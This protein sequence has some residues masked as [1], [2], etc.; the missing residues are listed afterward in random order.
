MRKW[1]KSEAKILY[2][3]SLDIFIGNVLLSWD[4]ESLIPNSPFE[5]LMS[6]WELST[7]IEISECI[8]RLG[9]GIVPQRRLLDAKTF[10]VHGQKIFGRIPLKK[11]TCSWI[12][13]V[14]SVRLDVHGNR[15]CRFRRNFLHFVSLVPLG[16]V[17]ISWEFCK[18]YSWAAP[19]SRSTR[20]NF[21]IW[22]NVSDH[23]S[24]IHLSQ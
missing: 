21:L 16:M 4:N 6:P 17:V 5:T 1:R 14:G 24:N 8:V 10:P 7:T 11:K 12:G 15:N 2:W 20:V 22:N 19:L 23:S 3:E 13:R 9:K 18:N